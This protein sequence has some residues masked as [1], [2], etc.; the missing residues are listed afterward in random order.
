MAGALVAYGVVG[1]ALVTGGRTYVA[2]G[3]LVA[4]SLAFAWFRW[5]SAHPDACLRDFIPCP[6]P[7]RQAYQ[8][9]LFLT[10][11]IAAGFMAY[12]IPAYL[13]MEGVRSLFDPRFH[14]VILNVIVL[15]QVSAADNR[16]PAKGANT[17]LVL[18]LGYLAL[19][20]TLFMF[21][22]WVA[23][24]TLAAVLAISHAQVARGLRTR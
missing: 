14:Q 20:G 13:W 2:A 18:N 22:S 10:G 8:A 9:D 16:R 11:L 17:V 6:T 4:A 15:A 23:L 1:A 3:T 12:L 19:S 7:P 5:Q 24:T 21:P